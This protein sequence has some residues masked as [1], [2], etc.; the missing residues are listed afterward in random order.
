MRRMRWYDFLSV[1]LFW[2]GLNI[3]NNAV[4]II[5]MPYLVAGF[6]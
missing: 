4:G 2:L 3:R 1:N 6:V 5:F